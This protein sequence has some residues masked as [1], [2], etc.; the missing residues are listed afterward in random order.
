MFPPLHWDADGKHY[1]QTISTNPPSREDVNTLQKL[2][3]EKLVIRQARYHLI[4]L[5]TQA[6]ALFDRNCID[7]ATMRSFDKSLS[8][9]LREGSF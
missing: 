3:D 8:T 7:S 6:S 9:L 4:Y 5:E 2:L 1:T